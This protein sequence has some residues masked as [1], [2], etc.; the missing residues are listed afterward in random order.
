ML[1]AMHLVKFKSTEYLVSMYL[2]LASY[3]SASVVEL[4]NLKCDSVWLRFKLM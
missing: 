4:V 3:I 1:I 2:A